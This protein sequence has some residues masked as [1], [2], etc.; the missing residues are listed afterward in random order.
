MRSAN[1]WTKRFALVCALTMLVAACGGSGSDEAGTDPPPPPPPPTGTAE[2]LWSGTTSTGRTAVGL[3]LNDGTYWVLYSLVGNSSQIAG[4]VQGTGD[5]QNG[6]FSSSDG[7]DFNFE[8][9]G[10]LSLT[11][12]ADYVAKQ[13]FDAAIEY[14]G[15][16]VSL[17]AT[18][19]AD[20][21]SNPSLS[22]IAGAYSGYAVTNG[23][24]E[25]ATATIS[26][27]GAV[28]GASA[29]GCTFSGVAA[30]RTNG[31]VYNVS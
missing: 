5:S 20:Y 30:P 8:G 2:G 11:F 10:I 17:P 6:N 4:V 22:I 9:A 28:T 26:A 23:G 25:A 12:D 18:Y 29:S 7:K 24:A 13:S 31:N 27:T 14:S 1:C 16:T 3:V 15:T 19:N 21:D